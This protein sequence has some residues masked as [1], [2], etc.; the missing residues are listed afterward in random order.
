MRN[1]VDSNV[2]VGQVEQKEVKNG[3]K[4]ITFL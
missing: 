4:S 2:E 3:M 1:K